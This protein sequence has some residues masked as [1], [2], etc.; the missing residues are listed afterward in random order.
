MAIAIRSILAHGY[1]NARKAD[2]W[3]LFVAHALATANDDRMHKS[4]NHMLAILAWDDI[5]RLAL[6]IYSCRLFRD[7][8][9]CFDITSS[10]L[11][12]AF[13]RLLNSDAMIF[14]WRLSLPL[15]TDMSTKRAGTS[16][17]NPATAGISA[18]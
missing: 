11:L 2:K 12:S 17:P 13:D 18:Q 3:I 16:T 15:L 6:R 1:A 10:W 4:R 5:S 8:D 9:G 7:V 14:N